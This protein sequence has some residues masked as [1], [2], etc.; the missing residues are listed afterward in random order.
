MLDYSTTSEQAGSLWYYWE[1]NCW[2]SKYKAFDTISVSRFGL[3]LVEHDASLLG[4]G[5][6]ASFY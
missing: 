4:N 1:L 2:S 5:L 3:F 6:A